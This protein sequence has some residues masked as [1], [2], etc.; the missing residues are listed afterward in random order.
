MSSHTDSVLQHIQRVFPNVFYVPLPAATRFIGIAPQTFRNKLCAGKP[1]FA[2]IERGGKR[3]VT[4]DELARFVAAELDAQAPAPA[5]APAADPAK[6]GRGRPRKL[7]QAG[8]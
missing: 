5:P 1:L 8:G 6:R 4:I 2:T 7:A 3:Y